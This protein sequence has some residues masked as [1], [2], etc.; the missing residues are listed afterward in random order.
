MISTS[1]T[2]FPIK[3]PRAR[4]S[5][6]TADGAAWRIKPEIRTLAAIVERTQRETRTS[7]PFGRSNKT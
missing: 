4:R 2:V 7:N 1:F 5:L 6:V 3:Q